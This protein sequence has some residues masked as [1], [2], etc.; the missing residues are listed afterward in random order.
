MRLAVLSFREVTIRDKACRASL[1][2]N[3]LYQANTRRILMNNRNA[4]PR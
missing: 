2:R 4:K 1:V 3:Y